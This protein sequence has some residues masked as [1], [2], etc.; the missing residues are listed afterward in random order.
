VSSEVIEWGH[1]EEDE[2]EGNGRRMA[3][4][5]GK[6]FYV[7][8]EGVCGTSGRDDFFRENAN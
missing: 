1:V 7:Y 5:N 3:G 6:D 8:P 2:N 4:G